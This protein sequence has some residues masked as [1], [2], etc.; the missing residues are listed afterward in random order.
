ME[1]I[2]LEDL[3]I[4]AY[5]DDVQHD[6]VSV[7]SPSGAEV[8]VM[9]QGEADYFNEISSRYTSDNKFMNISDLLELDRILI[10]ETVTYRWASWLMKGVDY[11]GRNVN[12]D[13]VQRSIALYSKEIREIKSA[14]GI[15]KVTRDKDK[16]SNLADYLNTLL[17]RAK[18]FGIHRDN[19]IVAAI[20]ILNEL[21]AAATANKNMTE[22]ERRE[23][24]Y[25]DPDI[26]DL[27]L[28]KMSEYEKIDEAFRKNQ[29]LWI[30]DINR[31]D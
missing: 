17:Q 18:E 23:F 24:G 7:V 15:D 4:G 5:I 14:L 3:D 11:Q 31:D 6:P 16:G 8:E 12:A 25:R 1:D 29:R 19:Q 9:T 20:N 13:Q 22:S 30:R 10:M 27:I 28:S 26:V 21:A 2:D